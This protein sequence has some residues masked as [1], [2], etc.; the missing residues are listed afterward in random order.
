MALQFFN[1]FIV[2]KNAFI[3]IVFHGGGVAY[4]CIS[5]LIVFF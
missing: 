2:L 3:G 1:Q 5:L 4:A